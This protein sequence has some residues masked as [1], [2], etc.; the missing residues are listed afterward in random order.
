ML[1][2]TTHI[3]AHHSGLDIPCDV[4]EAPDFPITT[5]VVLFFHSGGLIGRSREYVH[6]WLVQVCL[7]RKWPLISASYRLLPQTG[8]SGLV[9]D[10]AAAYR[11]AS[12]WKAPGR[13]VIAS[14]A[15]GGTCHP[16]RPHHHI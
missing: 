15:S 10:A 9:E 5:P 6:P 2:K 3:Y 11:F 7:E 14:G 13:K 8:P 12:N 4:Y 16:I 1:T